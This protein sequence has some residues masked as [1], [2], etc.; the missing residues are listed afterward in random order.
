MGQHDRLIAR[1]QYDPESGVWT[2][3]GKIA[4]RTC[5][6]GY[7]QIWFEG[8]SHQEHR[9]AWF[10]MTGAWPPNQIDHINL[11]KADNR[12]S[13]LRAATP[14]Q[15]RG[16]VPLAVINSSGAKGVTW[17]KS[18]RRWQACCAHKYIGVFKTR[19]LAHVAYMAAASSYYGEF[20]RPE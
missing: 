1:L 19:E 7:R 14:S 2:R 3:A 17:N 13:N 10:Y 11:D 12:W 9:L 8:R 15:Q 6:D 20:A 18:C 4:G 16:N 5:H